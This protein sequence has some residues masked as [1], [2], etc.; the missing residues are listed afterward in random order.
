MKIALIAVVAAAT[1][2][3]SVAFAQTPAPSSAMPAAPATPMAAPAMG[4]KAVSKECSMQ[5]DAQK[6]HGKARKTFRSKCKASGG[7]AA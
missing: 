3:A 4:K 7:K 6:L 1:L 2:S 5:A